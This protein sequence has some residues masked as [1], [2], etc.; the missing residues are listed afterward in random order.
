[1][2]WKK[3]QEI[4]ADGLTNTVTTEQQFFEYLCSN[5]ALL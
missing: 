4:H 3:D 1:M 5:V 2:N